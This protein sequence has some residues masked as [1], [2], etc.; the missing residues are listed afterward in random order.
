MTAFCYKGVFKV[1]SWKKVLRT[2][3][4]LKLGAGVSLHLKTCQISGR[5]EFT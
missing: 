2:E 4:S 1:V 5:V 3:D